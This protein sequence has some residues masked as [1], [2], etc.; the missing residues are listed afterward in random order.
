MIFYYIFHEMFHKIQNIFNFNSILYTY[1]NTTV[2]S[3]A[4]K[5]GQYNIV[6]LLLQ[7]LKFDIKNT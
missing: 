5:K 2:L 4:F 6:K 7:N 1:S 3:R